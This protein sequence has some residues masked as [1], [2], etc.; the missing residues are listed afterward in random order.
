MSIVFYVGY[1]E[2]GIILGSSA[3]VLLKCPE[4]Y[5]KDMHLNT[6]GE[7]TTSNILLDLTINMHKQM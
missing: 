6:C 4:C 5:L 2:L 7:T 1:V 3:Y